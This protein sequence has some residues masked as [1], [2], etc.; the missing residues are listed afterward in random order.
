MR[1]LI[2][3][4]TTAALAF[5]TAQ[6]IASPYPQATPRAPGSSGAVEDVSAS[7]PASRGR[8]L[9]AEH[10]SFCHGSNARGT[11][12][13][14]DLTQVPIVR[15]DNGAG[16]V[17]AIFLKHG[18]PSSGMPAFPSLTASEV[19]YIARFLHSETLKAAH[20]AKLSILVGNPAAGKKYFAGH[21]SSC[22]SVNGNLKGIASRLDPM[23]LQARIVNPRA[24]GLLGAPPPQTIP[25]VLP[26]APP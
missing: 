10:C 6:A 24:E 13:A 8:K 14:P 12:V 17:L 25:I 18:I 22:H 4:L 2:S 21:C 15:Q 9:F 19:H 23:T 3:L 7:H 26:D 5:V 16:R 20:Q 1:A 11:G